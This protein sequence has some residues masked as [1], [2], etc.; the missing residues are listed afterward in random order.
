MPIATQ[1]QKNVDLTHSTMKSEFQ[2]M[3]SHRA[4]PFEK[5][6]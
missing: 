3:K 6:C 4:T 5:E 1:M 2:C